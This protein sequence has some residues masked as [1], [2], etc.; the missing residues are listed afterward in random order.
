MRAVLLV[1]L[2]A[3]GATGRQAQPPTADAAREAPRDRHA[4]ALRTAGT[5]E[6]VTGERRHEPSA[7][8]TG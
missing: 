5:A 4:D 6:R 2:T 3:C 8:A 7:Q 1:V